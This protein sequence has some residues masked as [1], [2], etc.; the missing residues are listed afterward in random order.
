MTA[1]DDGGCRRPVLMGSYSVLAARCVYLHG[2]R[3][4]FFIMSQAEVDWGRAN[5]PFPVESNGQG[6][7]G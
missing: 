7:F 5:A 2:G 6:S 1:Y 3:V 4:A